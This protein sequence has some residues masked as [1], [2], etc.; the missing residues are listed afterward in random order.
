MSD[1]TAA[2]RTVLLKHSRS[3]V[4]HDGEP[5]DQLLTELVETAGRFAEPVRPARGRRREESNAAEF[6]A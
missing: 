3:L 2:F 5:T 6:P 1:L 4:D